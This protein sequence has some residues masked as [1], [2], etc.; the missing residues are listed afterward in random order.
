MEKEKLIK[1]VTEAQNGDSKSMN[2]LFNEFYNDVYYF[3]LKTVKSEDIAC[4]VTQETFI[5]IIRTINN[6]QEPVAF[7][8]WMKQITYHQCTRYFKKKKDV[9]VDEDEDGNTIFDTLKEDRVEFI[10]D[11]ALEQKEFKE[12]IL[13][14]ID[15]LSEE[16]RSA[17]MMYYFDELSVKEIAEIQGVSEG[18]VKSRLNYG[19]KA[20]KNSVEEYE[21]KNGVKLHAL[22]FFPLF[23]WLFKEDSKTKMATPIAKTVAKGVAAATK[24]SVHIG[25]GVGAK[26]AAVPFVVKMTSGVIALAVAAGGVA[27]AVLLNDN[28]VPAVNEDVSTT[29]SAE[30]TTEESTDFIEESNPAEDIIQ[31][32][33]KTEDEKPEVGETEEGKTEEKPETPPVVDE[34]T[35]KNQ[36][37]SIAR[38]VYYH[39]PY[40]NS[41]SKLSMEDVANYIY[42][43]YIWGA[44]Y[45]KTDIGGGYYTI[46]VPVSDFEKYS[47]Q[48]FGRTYNFKELDGKKIDLIAGYADVTY[49]KSKDTLTIKESWGGGGDVDDKTYEVKK[50]DSTNYVVIMSYGAWTQTPPTMDIPYETEVSDY[51]G[52]TYYKYTKTEEVRLVLINGDFQIKSRVQTAY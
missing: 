32:E 2:I 10:P 33:G 35:L 18:T 13:E 30:I 21:K 25:V 27:T 39:L 14:I 17:I 48:A 47:K 46:D 45:E 24:T 37:I 31:E 44:G 50:I 42:N 40:F 4:D 36:A 26:I 41:T 1:L 51:D 6:L 34:A 23:K 3:A 16:Q 22:P 19:R 49:N 38:G 20:I 29:V 7:V 43:E 9:L 28:N 8:T 5:E 52:K 15:S 12:T 11:E